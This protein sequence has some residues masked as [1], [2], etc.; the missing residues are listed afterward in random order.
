MTEPEPETGTALPED[1]LREVFLRVEQRLCLSQASRV[2]RAWRGVVI[3]ADFRT[4]WS[5]RHY[6]LTDA[7]QKELLLVASQQVQCGPRLG[8]AIL[9]VAARL[10]ES[11]RF[12]FTTVS[13]YCVESPW[14]YR[15]QYRYKGPLPD[16]WRYLPEEHNECKVVGLKLAG[17]AAIITWTGYYGLYSDVEDHD[18]GGHAHK[19][20]SVHA[21]LGGGEGSSPPTIHVACE[22]H[23]ENE[24]MHEC[25]EDEIGAPCMCPHPETECLCEQSHCSRRCACGHCGCPAPLEPEHEIHPE[26]MRLLRSLLEEA[27]C[28]PSESAVPM[29]DPQLILLFESAAWL[30]AVRRSWKRSTLINHM[31]KLAANLV[32]GPGGGPAHYAGSKCSLD[33]ACGRSPLQ[34]LELLFWDA[35]T[36]KFCQDGETTTTVHGEIAAFLGIDVPGDDD[37]DD[38]KERE[39]CGFGGPIA[40]SIYELRTPGNVLPV[41]W[42]CL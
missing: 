36:D 19:C 25:V 38:E 28:L 14:E 24:A 35:P 15:K 3:A 30:W 7:A 40:T 42:F 37:Y 29:S 21:V 23:E 2:S 10:L 33:D 41:Q 5:A 22:M 31:S 27:G 11:L 4:D 16:D 8:E 12:E 13:D 32:L 20:F 9:P 6:G 18:G 39:A 1:L 17:G 34:G 26:G